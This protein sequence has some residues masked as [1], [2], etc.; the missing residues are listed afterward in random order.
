MVYKIKHAILWL[1]SAL[2]LI[3]GGCS[4]LKPPSEESLQ[5]WAQPASWEG[6]SSLPGFQNQSRY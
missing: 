6:Q 4:A 3:A 5:P 2:L 1:G